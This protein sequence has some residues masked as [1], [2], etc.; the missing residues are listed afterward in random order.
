MRDLGYFVLSVFRLIDW[1]GAFFVSRYKFNT[2]IYDPVTDE[3]IDL[4]ELLKKARR[5]GQ[6]VIDKAVLLGKEEKLP[7]RFVAILVPQHIAQQR[8]RKASKD[9]H[10]KT[11]HSTEYMET[12]EWS[13]FVTNVPTQIWTPQQLLE[14]YGFRW[15]IEVI[16][17]AWKS[18]FKVAQLFKSKNSMA[19][20]RAIITFWLILLWLCLFFVK[21]YHFFL[22]AVFDKKQK[23]LSILKFAKFVKQH[24]VQLVNSDDL[25]E[26]IDLLAKYYCYD[27]RKYP[28]FIEKLYMLK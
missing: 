6:T 17:K 7:V 10:S 16:F 3:L 11:N 19:V 21:W 1:M 25:N 28:N 4:N 8:K 23:W 27:K 14:A 22:Q 20:P 26:F 13:I 12:L 2:H 9:R 15:R 5:E 24:F 18:G